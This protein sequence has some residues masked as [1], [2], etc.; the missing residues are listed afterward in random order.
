MDTQLIINLGGAAIIASIGW[1]CK[2]IWDAVHTLQEDIHK[3]E[4]DLP[5]NYIRR[6]EF[7]DNMREIKDMLYKIFERLDTKADR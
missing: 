7:H 3:L 1:F 2:A 5:A 6:D 4:V